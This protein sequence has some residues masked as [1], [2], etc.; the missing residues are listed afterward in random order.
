MKNYYLLFWAICCSIQLTQAQTIS[1]SELDPVKKNTL[2]LEL[3]SPFNIRGVTAD[4]GEA[5]LFNAF[6][7][8]QKRTK[9]SV[10]IGLA[11]E[12]AIKKDIVL[13]TRF[14]MSMIDLYEERFEETEYGIVEGEQT[15][16]FMSRTESQQIHYNLFL[17]VA[18]KVK[19]SDQFN[20]DI[21]LE[22]AT[23]LI[24]NGAVA[25][26]TRTENNS[27]FGK[28]RATD[29]FDA[30]YA[31]STSFGIGPVFKP[32][33][34]FPMGLTIGLEFQLFFMN[35][36]ANDK[37][38]RE[39][40]TESIYSDGLLENVYT[41]ETKTEVDFELNQWSWSQASPMLKIGYRF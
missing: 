41:V 19:V 13:R 2:W 20:I 30:T 27:D 5:W 9:S 21:G 3:Y 23:I 34:V 8:T 29:E 14:G 40:K 16:K 18:K 4:F 11:Y 7:T 31:T 12:R 25:S 15:Y 36:I 24:Q 39:T 1:E 17:G 26:I 22:L 38:T 35:T 32:E 28:Q 33:Y 37:T 6:G 10:A